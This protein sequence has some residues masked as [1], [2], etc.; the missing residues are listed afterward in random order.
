MLYGVVSRN[1]AQLPAMAE[2]PVY[3]PIMELLQNFNGFSA[4]YEYLIYH[5]L[6]ITSSMPNQISPANHLDDKRAQQISEYSRNEAEP[7]T[8]TDAFEAIASKLDELI[9]DAEIPTFDA[10]DKVTTRYHYNEFE[11]ILV[12][13]RYWQ[14]SGSECR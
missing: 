1:F 10:V 3:L 11:A 5:I 13:G 14:Q 9:H 7:I 12:E 2:E 4:I 8:K 6:P